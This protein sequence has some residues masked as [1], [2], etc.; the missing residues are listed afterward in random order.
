MSGPEKKI[1][2]EKA[3]DLRPGDI[4]LIQTP[5]PIYDLFRKLG[6]HNFDHMV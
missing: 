2:I 1:A 6:D 3:K 5:S 4:I